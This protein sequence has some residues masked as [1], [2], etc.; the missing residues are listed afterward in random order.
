MPGW[1]AGGMYPVWGWA[2]GCWKEGPGSSSSSYSSE[3]SW[4]CFFF[5]LSVRNTQHMRLVTQSHAT[6][7]NRSHENGSKHVSVRS[8]SSWRLLF[9]FLFFLY[10]GFSVQGLSFSPPCLFLGYPPCRRS[11]AQCLSFQ[12]WH[13]GLHQ[14]FLCVPTSGSTSKTAVINS[15]TSDCIYCMRFYSSHKQQLEL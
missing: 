14:L 7:V 9:V 10:L 12:V 11:P 4:F 13:W 5:W 8:S 1:V 6:H 15:M 2:A 3:S